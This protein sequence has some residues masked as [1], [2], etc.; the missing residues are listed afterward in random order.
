MFSSVTA[1]IY[2]NKFP[3]TPNNTQFNIICSIDRWHLGGYFNVCHSD[4]SGASFCAIHLQVS[5]S[6][7]VCTTGAQGAAASSAKEIRGRACK[8]RDSVENDG[9]VPQLWQLNTR[10]EMAMINHWNDSQ[11]I[12][13]D[14]C[15]TEVSLSTSVQQRLGWRS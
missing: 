15:T 5:A 12:H 6:V 9:F 8:L 2:S 14:G 7:C 10:G 13:R 4:V 3:V 11:Y 1:W